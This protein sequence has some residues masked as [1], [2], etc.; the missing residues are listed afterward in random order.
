M[1]IEVIKVREDT[2]CIKP[3]NS[4]IITLAPHKHS[5]VKLHSRSR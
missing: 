5:N 4:A 1:G 3:E 2:I